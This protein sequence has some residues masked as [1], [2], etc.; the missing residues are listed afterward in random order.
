[1]RRRRDSTLL[2]STQ[3]PRA[4]DSAGLGALGADAHIRGESVRADPYRAHCEG[5]PDDDLLE[6]EEFSKMPGVARI[7]V[8]V[9]LRPVLASELER[10]EKHIGNKM[11]MDDRHVQLQ[12]DR[13]GQGHESLRNT[14]KTY[15]FDAVFHEGHTQ[16]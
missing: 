3:T 1:M 12:H 9:R 4:V 6:F 16:A 7:Q 14:F 13:A 11:Q 2:T 8:A 15:K 5:E 10:G